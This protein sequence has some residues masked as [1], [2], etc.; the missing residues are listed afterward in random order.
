[1][2]VFG[3]KVS[4][5]VMLII[6]FFALLGLIFWRISAYE[7]ISKTSLYEVR[8]NQVY[9]FDSEKDRMSYQWQVFWQ[10][11]L[12]KQAEKGEQ[13]TYMGQSKSLSG[14]VIA[15]GD[16]TYTYGGRGQV[17]EIDGLRHSIVNGSG[18]SINLVG[19]K[20]YNLVLRQDITKTNYRLDNGGQTIHF[21]VLSGGVGP[22]DAA[23][24]EM[25]EE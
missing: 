5:T 15:V 6:G 9:Q 24:L 11:E 17:V 22:K 23:Y 7:I 3:K 14:E 16:M 1:M 20:T 8:S 10:A 4:A 19:G 12:L 18:Y 2:K 13:T 25:I 21:R